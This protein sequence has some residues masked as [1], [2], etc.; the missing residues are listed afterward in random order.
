MKTK[1]LLLIGL[2]TLGCTTDNTEEIDC[3]CGTI[4][5]KMHFTFPNFTVLKVK[6]DCTGVVEQLNLDGNQGELNGKWCQ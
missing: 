5:S 6:N 2:C 4:I 1:L 3:G